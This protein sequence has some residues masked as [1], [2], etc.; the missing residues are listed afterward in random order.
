MIDRFAM[1]FEIPLLW[2][3]LL[4]ALA[5][6]AAA[7]L[8]YFFYAP[9][10]IFPVSAGIA[11]AG[12][13]LG[14]Y[15]L[16]PAIFLPGLAVYL[17]HS[18]HPAIA[19]S[20]AMGN[21]L[22]PIVA[23]YVLRKLRFDPLMRS[24]RDIFSLL[25]VTIGAST[26]VPTVVMLG[27]RAGEFFGG[28]PLAI[29]W[30]AY[31]VGHMWSLLII[32]PFMIRWIAKPLFVRT[33][34]ERI[35]TIAGFALLF[36]IDYL[37]FWTPYVSIRGISLVYLILI[38]FF[39]ISLRFGPRFVSLALVSTSA[40][41]L[42]GVVFG[43][44]AAATTSALGESLFQTQVFL[45]VIALIYYTVTL[46]ATERRHA[47][48]ALREQVSRLENALR[49]ISGEDS[50]KT[51][52][53]ALLAHELRNPLAP[54]RSALE[55]L[56]LKGI[57]SSEAGQ[58]FEM[59]IERV[60]TMGRLLDD[61]LDMSR[62]SRKKM[63]LRLETVELSSLIRRSVMA[64]NEL[65][66]EKT[67]TCEIRTPQQALC[68]LGDPVRLEQILVNILK[69]AVK[70]TDP[71]GHITVSLTQKGKAGVIAIR[72]NGVGIE[73]HM[74]KRIFEPFVQG[75]RDTP[76]AGSGLGVG[77]SLTKM[78]VEMHNGTIEAKS[79]G[80]GKG[81]EFII[82]LGL[83]QREGAKEP[84]QKI[85]E[86]AQPALV[87]Q[88]VL[89]VD[90]NVPAAEGM[91]K[92]LKHKGYTTELSFSGMDALS[93]S[94]SFNPDAI[95]LDI[96]LPDVEG[97]EVARILRSAED[98]DGTLVAMT[99]YGLRDDKQKARD[100]GFDHHLTKPVSI[101]DVEALFAK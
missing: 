52:F 95:L 64:V 34:M 73:S 91:A 81:S 19:I 8:S 18:T 92:L 94:K 89:V 41:A 78:L 14:G 6:A 83:V 48:V 22:Q 2:R 51:E 20:L 39:W 70:Y 84:I 42:F 93:K 80:R 76:R 25:V 72:D 90:D 56:K 3:Y 17:I 37:L 68:V 87:I 71:G 36:T 30:P 77:L 62:I 75:S 46:I 58:L 26:I 10:A 28:S 74:L 9:P 88:K 79:E 99:G 43:P 31:W 32:G 59:M 69:N 33:L 101:N 38:P 1:R 21:T 45:I 60:M 16:A 98:F 49:H 47:V 85:A 55:I 82:C 4:L 86:A 61:L 57:K 44:L 96:G 29:S 27:Y 54:I 13:V 12:V 67:H 97:Y 11:L 53:L 7:E 24:T 40:I 100:A 23:A 5:Y 50:A 15:R 66:I 35:E 63:N 65:A